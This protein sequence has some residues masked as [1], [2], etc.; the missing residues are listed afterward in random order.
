L[1]N[2][3]TA[4]VTV[5][6]TA[7]LSVPLSVAVMASDWPELSKA[8]AGVTAIETGISDSTAL[9]LLPVDA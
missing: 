8:V 3:P 2:V 9:P 6:L 4:G 5:Q 7:K 1:A